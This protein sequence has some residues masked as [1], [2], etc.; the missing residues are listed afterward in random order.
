MASEQILWS[1]DAAKI[2]WRIC[3]LNCRAHLANRSICALCCTCPVMKRFLIA[4][5]VALFLT[6]YS[7]VASRLWPYGHC[8]N[9]LIHFTGTKILFLKNWHQ[10]YHPFIPMDNP[11]SPQIWRSYSATPS[12][13]QPTISHLTWRHQRRKSG[14]S[15]D[16]DLVWRS[17]G[18]SL[19]SAYAIKTGLKMT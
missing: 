4:E 10:K 2:A 1:Q 7:G 3:G 5:L 9:A 11:E 12:C 14:F 16:K 17:L 19:R 8:P 13:F 6:H 15:C 18:A